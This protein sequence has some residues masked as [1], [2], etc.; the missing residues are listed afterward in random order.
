MTFAGTF[1]TGLN[2]F[3]GTTGVSSAPGNAFSLLSTATGFLAGRFFGP[4]AEEVG[5]VWNLYDGTR[6]ANGVLVGGR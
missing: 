2:G 4:T 1:T 3:T 5:A 6:I